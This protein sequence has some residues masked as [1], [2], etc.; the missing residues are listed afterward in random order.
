[1]AGRR[2]NKNQRKENSSGRIQ[3]THLLSFCCDGRE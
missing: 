2:D 1:V 3:V